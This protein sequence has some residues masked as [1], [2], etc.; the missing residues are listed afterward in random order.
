MQLRSL[1]GVSTSEVED[2]TEKHLQES[3]QNS[4]LKKQAT[5]SYFLLCYPASV[6]SL[7]I[8]IL[9]TLMEDLLCTNQWHTTIF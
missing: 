4:V 8:V 6:F 5:L 1:R 9:Q 2:K 7:E 3:F